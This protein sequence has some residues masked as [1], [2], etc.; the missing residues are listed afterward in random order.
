MRDYAC[1]CLHVCMCVYELGMGSGFSERWSEYRVGP[2][3]HASEVQLPRSYRMF[4]NFYSTT[5]HTIY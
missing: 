2:L 4:N 1:V 3:K 5:N